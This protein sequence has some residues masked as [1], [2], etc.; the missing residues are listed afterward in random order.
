[1]DVSGNRG[2]PKSSI[3]IGFSI[4]NHPFWGFPPIFGN[5]HI[6]SFLFFFNFS[7]CSKTSLRSWSSATS[8]TRRREIRIISDRD[9]GGTD[10]GDGVFF[11]CF[12]GKKVECFIVVLTTSHFFFGWGGCSGF[13]WVWWEFLISF[14]QTTTS[15]S[16]A[17]QWC[18]RWCFQKL[19]IFEPLAHPSLN[20][21]CVFGGFKIVLGCFWQILHHPD[22]T[23][24]AI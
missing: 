19:L 22:H 1:M 20:S 11:F 16:C 2:T 9:G 21:S 14:L 3:L 17:D 12:L 24:T 10:G 6:V 4:I 18:Q 5:T 8:A 13:F 23:Q 7:F 15:V